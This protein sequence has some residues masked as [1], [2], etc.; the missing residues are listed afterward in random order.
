M[1]RILL[2]DDQ[3]N[4]RKG[5]RM[6]LELEDGL[7]VVGEA[8][9]GASALA[10]ART[11]S[12]DLILMDVE[13]PGMDGIAATEQLVKES[14]DCPVVVLTIHDDPTTRERARSAG[15]CGFVSKHEIDGS[16]VDAIHKACPRAFPDR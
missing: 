7:N 11:L 4:V 15:A 16:L 10:L 8:A 6:R 1:I 14:P 3:G 13:M 2:A 12:P 5:L 9:D